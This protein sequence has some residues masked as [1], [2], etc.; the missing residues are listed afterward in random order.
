MDIQARLFH[1]GGDA[2]K[3][4][5]VFLVGR[6]VHD[7]AAGALVC[8]NAQIAPKAGIGGCD[9][10]GLRQQTLGRGHAMQPGLEQALTLGI[11]PADLLR[12]GG[13]GGNGGWEGV[14][15]G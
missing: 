14:A 2:H 12:L 9:A 1:Q 4:L 10:Q 3:G 7:D 8:V 13:G 5:G 15:H 11:A 6:R